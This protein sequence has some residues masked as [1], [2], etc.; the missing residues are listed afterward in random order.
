MS[1]K[2]A[3][4]LAVIFAIAVIIVQPATADMLTGECIVPPDQY[5]VTDGPMNGQPV[6]EGLQLGF[7]FWT[8]DNGQNQYAGNHYLDITEYK[9]KE[10]H[11]EQEK[12]AMGK[13]FYCQ[14]I[15]DFPYDPDFPDRWG[16]HVSEDP[17]DSVYLST[18]EMRARDVPA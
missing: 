6:H 10:S 3:L 16:A 8:Y 17:Y 11:N 5:F 1:M 14:T 4:M 18:Q 12:I 9:L 13:M 2:N 7:V 15:P